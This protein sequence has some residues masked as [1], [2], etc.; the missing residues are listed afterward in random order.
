M[1]CFRLF[2]SFVKPL[3]TG[4]L[5]DAEVLLTLHLAPNRITYP[6]GVVRHGVEI[7]SMVGQVFSTGCHRERLV[8][9]FF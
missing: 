1:M 9:G 6:I 2:C 4:V 5:S 8:D 7:V 3:L